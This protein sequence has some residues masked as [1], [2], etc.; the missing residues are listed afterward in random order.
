[1]RGVFILADDVGD[2]VRYVHLD[3]TNPHK[4]FSAVD[5]DQQPGWVT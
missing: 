1:L 2:R 4:D 3:F 5:T